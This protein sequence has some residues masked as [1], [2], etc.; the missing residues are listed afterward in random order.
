[1]AKSPKVLWDNA[2]HRWGALSFELSEPAEKGP[3]K[4]GIKCLGRTA[5]CAG[6]LAAWDAQLSVEEPA[7]QR[8]PGPPTAG[9]LPGGRPLAGRSQETSE[10]LRDRSALFHSPKAFFP[11][12]E[13]DILAPPPTVLSLQAIFFSV[14]ALKVLTPEHPPLLPPKDPKKKRCKVWF[15]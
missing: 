9:P 8:A 6:I 12:Q 14:L 7:P 1:M 13:P 10:P 3:V 15:R 11:S 5:G 2:W 4:R